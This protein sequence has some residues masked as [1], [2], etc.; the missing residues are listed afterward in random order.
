MGWSVC[1]ILCK[2]VLNQFS[3]ENNEKVSSTLNSFV[4]TMSIYRSSK[5]ISDYYSWNLNL[6]WLWLHLLEIFNPNIHSSHYVWNLLKYIDERE[7]PSW[8]D[9][10]WIT[11]TDNGNKFLWRPLLESLSICFQ[12]FFLLFVMCSIMF[13][14]KFVFHQKNTFTV[15]TWCLF[16][17][18][19][20]FAVSFYTKKQNLHSRTL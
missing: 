15:W 5:P 8:E 19:W 12:Q 11:S 17:F 10:R 20:S 9:H 13:P 1:K 7:V 14:C 4:A 3:K 18:A 2:I 16:K 6:L